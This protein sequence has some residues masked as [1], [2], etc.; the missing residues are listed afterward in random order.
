VCR[1]GVAQGTRTCTSLTR[2]CASWWLASSMARCAR[3]SRTPP[4][5]SWRVTLPAPHRSSPVAVVWPNRSARASL[6]ARSARS[7][8][9]A[10]RAALPRR[11]PCRPRGC[12]GCSSAALRAAGLRA[13]D[14]R[15]DSALRPGPRTATVGLARPLERGGALRGARP[16]RPAARRHAL[17]ASDPGGGGWW[18]RWL[19]GVGAGGLGVP[20]APVGGPAAREGGPRVLGWNASAAPP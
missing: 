8:R 12:S 1:R 13:P 9:R 4:S 14:R 11:P 7:A 17:Q 18:P 15:L 5:K 6:R 20:V 3:R 2:T 16:R 10:G 19:G